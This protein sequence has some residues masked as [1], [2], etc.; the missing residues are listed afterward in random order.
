MLQKHCKYWCFWRAMCRKHGKYRGFWRNVQKT[1]YV[2]RFFCVFCAFWLQSIGIYVVF[3]SPTAENCVNS[4]VLERFW[5]SGKQKLLVFIRFRERSAW[6]TVGFVGF[7][8]LFFFVFFLSFFETID[9]SCVQTKRYPALFNNVCAYVHPCPWSFH[10]GG[11]AG[12][13]SLSIRRRRNAGAGHG[14]LGH[15]PLARWPD[16]LTSFAHRRCQQGKRIRVRGTPEK[17]TF[18]TPLFLKKVA[19]TKN[20]INQW[21]SLNKKINAR[22]GRSRHINMQDPWIDWKHG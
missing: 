13:R 14:Q 5:T 6:K 17:Y 22:A 16:I 2:L 8:C 7:A 12:V 1:L 15:T 21:I 18:L 11:I 19:V 20:E 10:L 9:R 4:M 3:W